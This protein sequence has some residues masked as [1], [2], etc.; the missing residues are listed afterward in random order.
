MNDAHSANLD[1]Y[2]KY[3]VTLVG[4]GGRK[5]E[6]KKQRRTRNQQHAADGL[7]CHEGDVAKRPCNCEVATDRRGAEISV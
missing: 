6:E 4:E 1:G 3:Y 7:L 5:R 2:G